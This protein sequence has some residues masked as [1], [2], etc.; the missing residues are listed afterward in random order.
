MATIYA[1]SGALRKRGEM[2]ELPALV[3]FAD[4]LEAACIDVLN[5]GIMTKD[6][7]GLVDAGTPVKSVNSIDFIKAIRNRLEALL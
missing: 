5:S 3:D 2:D 4:K 1:W 7:A 6:L